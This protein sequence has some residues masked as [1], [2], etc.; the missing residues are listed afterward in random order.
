MHD[1]KFSKGSRG[2]FRGDFTRDSFDPMRHFSRILMQ[3]GRV[4]LD[5]DWNEQVSILL[6]YMRQLGRDLMGPHGAPYPDDTP[7]GDQHPA[8]FKINPV[9][10]QSDGKPDFSIASGRYYVNGILC[11]IGSEEKFS[12]RNQPNYS[13]TNQDELANRKTYLVYLDV[14]E[15]HLTYVEDDY[16]REKALGGA[17]TATRAQIVWQVK[18]ISD[19]ELKEGKNFLKLTEIT[20]SA[21]LKYSLFIDALTAAQRTHPGTGRLK[22]RAKKNAKEKSGPCLTAPEARYRGVENQLYRVEIHKG[23]GDQGGPTFKWSRENGSVIFPVSDI[24]GD[25]IT[26]EHLGRDDR[27]GLQ[28]GDWVEVIDDDVTLRNEANPLLKVTAVDRENLQVTLEDAPEFGVG[29]GLSKHFY[30]RRWDQKNGGE[31]G[32]SNGVSITWKSKKTPKT[33]WIALEDGVEVQFLKFDS[34]GENKTDFQYQSG[35]YWLIPARTATGDVEWP[36]GDS[37][38]PAS[39]SP[40]GVEHHYAPLAIITVENGSVQP[41]P[42]DLRRQLNQG[43]K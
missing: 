25:I 29:L 14:W 4:Q 31:N 36:R 5:A 18:V 40:H 2:E 34:T 21:D 9:E 12:Y 3:Q 41:E 8:N 1:D 22:A 10:K 30:L 32:M 28:P 16:M 17:D 24:S 43:W 27:F 7:T 23:S 37:D 11:E 19:Q 39:L 35:E 26:L 38:E 15:R 20:Q 42:K 13:L 6:H 33:N